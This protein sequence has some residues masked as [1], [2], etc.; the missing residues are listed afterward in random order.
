MAVTQGTSGFGTLLKRGDGGAP[1]AFTTVAEIYQLG[2][3]SPSREQ[4][5]MTH[6]ESP[7]QYREFIASFKDGGEISFSCNFLPDNA[8]QDATSGV[9]SIFEDGTKSNWQIV[10]P[11]TGSTTAAFSAYVQTYNVNA[12]ID[13][14]LSLDVTLKV[15]GVITWS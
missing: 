15:D 8:T 13:D 3:P 7:S 10:F 2:G 4:I 14:K 5:D 6:H 11:N 1:E 9:L 12:P